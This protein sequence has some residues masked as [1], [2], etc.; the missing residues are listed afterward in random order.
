M[1]KVKNACKCNLLCPVLKS[2][3]GGDFILLLFVFRTHLYYYTGLFVVSDATVT[4]NPLQC[5][6]DAH[7]AL[8]FIFSCDSLFAGDA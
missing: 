5:N 7:D 3:L 8:Q 6:S 1:H 4:R 2:A